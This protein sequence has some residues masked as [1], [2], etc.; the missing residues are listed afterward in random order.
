LY[1]APL[2]GSITRRIRHN[3]SATNHGGMQQEFNKYIDVVA[4]LIKIPAP[5]TSSKNRAANIIIYCIARQS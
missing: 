5:Q 4:I 2:T 1:D 3:H